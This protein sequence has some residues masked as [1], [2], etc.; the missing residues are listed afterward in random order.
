M[1][2]GRGQRTDGTDQNERQKAWTPTRMGGMEDFGDTNPENLLC[3]TNQMEQIDAVILSDQ[4]P[5]SGGH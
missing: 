5:F 1:M 4:T 2:I 3:R